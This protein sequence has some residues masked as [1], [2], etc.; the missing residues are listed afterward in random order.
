M[1]PVIELKNISKK[2]F[3]GGNLGYKTLRESLTV[4]PFRKKKNVFWALKD[5]S[6]KIAS[7]ETIG[8]IGENGSGKS[9]LLKILSRI[10][11]PTKGSG[12]VNGRVGCL[13]EVGTGFHPEL[14]GKENIYLNG[15]ILNL[16]KKEIDRKFDEIVDFAGVGRF[17]DTPLKRYSTG[18]WARLAFSVAAHL[19]PDILLVDEVL[20]VGDAEF[21]KKSLEKM[22]DLSRRGLTLVFVSHNMAALRTLCS[23]CI[24]LNKGEMKKMGPADEVIDYYMSGFDQAESGAIDLSSQ[25]ACKDSRNVRLNRIELRN[26]HGQIS[27]AFFLKDDLNI[28]LFLEASAPTERVKIIVRI[29][30][31]G[32]MPICKVYDSDSGFQLDNINGQVHVSI[33]FPDLRFYPGRYFV[34]LMIID[35]I[36]NYRHDRYEETEF[37]ISFTMKNQLI[38]NRDLSRHYGL[39]LMTPDWKIH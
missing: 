13:L 8:V 15:V 32:G 3:L 10:T 5:I 30:D 22:S 27:G 24:F 21:Q 35:E 6:L 16:K 20:S 33:C 36:F 4:L 12:R 23:K 2:Y 7:G 38:M 34:S 25:T 9:T 19:E 28:H 18:M 14:T 26:Q 39:L 29:I 37:V 1:K 31:S 17:L 11:N